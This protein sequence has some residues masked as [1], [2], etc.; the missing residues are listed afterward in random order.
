MTKPFEIDDQRWEALTEALLVTHFQ[1]GR[2]AL[3][4]VVDTIVTNLQSLCEVYPH[5]NTLFFS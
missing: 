1:Y 5:P 4:T 3:H 2:Q